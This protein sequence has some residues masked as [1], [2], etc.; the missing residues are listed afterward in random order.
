MIYAKRSTNFWQYLREYARQ[1]DLRHS[2]LLGGKFPK[3]KTSFA[4]RIFGSENMNIQSFLEFL[5]NGNTNEL[6]SIESE[7]NLLNV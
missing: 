7:A 5:S 6:Q 1:L 3:E 2:K 4:E